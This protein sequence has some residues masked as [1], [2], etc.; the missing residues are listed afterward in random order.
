MEIVCVGNELLIGK[1]MNTNA[2][3]LSKRATTLGID[4]KRI[5]VVRDVVTEIAD[6]LCEVLKRKPKFLITT[7]G[8]GPTF[9]DMTLKGV[10]KALHRKLAVNAEAIQMVKEKY[11]E[12][13]KTRNIGGDEMTEPRVK[14]ATLPEGTMPIK[15]PM[16]TAPG[17]RADVDGTVLI[18]LP[19]VPAEMEAI[20]ESYVVPLLR[21]ASGDMGFYE[22]SIFADRIMESVLAPLIDTVMGDNPCVYIKSHPRRTENKPHIEL[23]FSTSGKASEKPEEKLQR[24]AVQLSGLIGEAGG[25][26]FAEDGNVT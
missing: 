3:W 6:V 9:D 22:Q 12:Y 1:V 23:H 20:F 15:N 18:V 26:I 7:G 4:V 8:L 16:G 21:K 19:G 11:T 25:K 13:A 24:A 5:T 2:H 17:V 10:A 14:M